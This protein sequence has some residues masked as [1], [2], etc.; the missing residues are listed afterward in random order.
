MG[1]PLCGSSTVVP[2]L[3]PPSPACLSRAYCAVMSTWSICLIRH[4]L[5]QKTRFD[6][7]KPSTVR[8]RH[9]S[10]VAVSSRGSPAPLEPPLWLPHFFFFSLSALFCSSDFSNSPRGNLWRSYSPFYTLLSSPPP[11]L[12]FSHRLLIPVAPSCSPPPSSACSC[13]PFSSFRFLPSS[14]LFAPPGAPLK[15]LLYFC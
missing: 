11:R 9:V 12:H 2:P 8:A 7:K 4:R 15:G 14:F 10:G 6:G 3:T 5:A 1:G 13:F